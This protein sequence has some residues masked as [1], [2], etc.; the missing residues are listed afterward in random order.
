MAWCGSQVKA[1]QD[2]MAD[3]LHGWV[4]GQ[5]L[6]EDGEVGSKPWP[7]LEEAKD[8]CWK[9]QKGVIERAAQG[10]GADPGMA[11]SLEVQ[12]RVLVAG[13]RT[14]RHQEKSR[15]QSSKTQPG[16]RETGYFE[17][18]EQAWQALLGSPETTI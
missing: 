18:W 13:Y 10:A 2:L 12:H 8:R 1:G 15:S 16:R 5:V 6:A 14:L 3:G 11:A 4:C 17:G 7:G 9:N